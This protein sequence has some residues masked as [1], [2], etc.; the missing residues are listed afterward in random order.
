MY[1]VVIQADITSTVCSPVLGRFALVGIVML[2]FV[3]KPYIPF[4]FDTFM[5]MSNFSSG[6]VD[7]HI[8]YP[9]GQIEIK[10]DDIW[11]S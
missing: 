4:P 10:K 7:F 8:I 3:S 2:V 5:G 11:S 6:Q 9:D 1:A